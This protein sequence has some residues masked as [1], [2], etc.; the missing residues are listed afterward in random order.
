MG[1]STLEIRRFV[2]L[3]HTVE[4]AVDTKAPA[5]LQ[6]AVDAAGTTAAPGAVPD[7]SNVDDRHTAFDR[8]EHGCLSPE[9]RE[10]SCEQTVAPVDEQ[11]PSLDVGAA[12]A[13]AAIQAAAAMRARLSAM[14]DNIDDP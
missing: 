8:D 1:L 10:T 11:D 4:A 14:M 7:D 3:R 5:E 13:A 12:E 2:R 9:V 6:T